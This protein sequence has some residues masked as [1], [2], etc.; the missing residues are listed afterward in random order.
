L[1]RSLGWCRGALT[2]FVAVS[3]EL[4]AVVVEV[5]EVG[6]G[7]VLGVSPSKLLN[8]AVAVA[9]AQPFA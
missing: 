7:L 1:A 2:A 3:A 6:G 4:A 9:T 8:H 5:A